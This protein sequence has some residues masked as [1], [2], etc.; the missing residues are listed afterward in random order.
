MRRLADPIN[1]HDPGFPSRGEF[2]ASQSWVAQAGE[3]G[4]TQPNAGSLSNHRKIFERQGLVVSSDSQSKSPKVVSQ[5]FAFLVNPANPHRVADRASLSGVIHGL[6][7][8]TRS[9]PG[10]LGV[11]WVRQF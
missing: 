7:Q 9:S 3:A 11:C 6:A 5:L 4:G 2:A 10:G 1:E 8:H